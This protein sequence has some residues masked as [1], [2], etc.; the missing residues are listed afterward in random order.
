MI[1]VII[2]IYLIIILILR[3]IIHL[4][5]SFHLIHLPIYVSHQCV[6]NSPQYQI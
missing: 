2:F 4:K 5:H 3:S 6:N 1:H